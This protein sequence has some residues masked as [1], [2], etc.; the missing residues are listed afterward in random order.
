M[1][2]L[3]KGNLIERYTFLPIRNIWRRHFSLIF[4][5]FLFKIQVAQKKRVSD[6][7]DLCTII[8]I[9]GNICMGNCVSSACE[10]KNSGVDIEIKQEIEL[11]EKPIS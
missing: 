1:I 9:N 5:S 4:V 7:S 11:N 6:E 2:R 10:T 3:V 8:G